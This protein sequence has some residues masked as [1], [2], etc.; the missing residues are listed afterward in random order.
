METEAKEHVMDGSHDLADGHDRPSVIVD[1][2]GEDRVVFSLPPTRR[3]DFT[4]VTAFALNKSGSVLLNH[5]LRDLCA[6]LD[7]PFVAISEEFF[8]AGVK[9]Q[10]APP[11]TSDIFLEKGYCYGGFRRWPTSFAI[12]ILA[13]SRPVL[14]VRDPRDRL[15]SNYYSMRES[16]SQPGKNGVLKSAKTELSKRNLAKSLDIDDYV[17]EVAPLFLEQLELYRDELCARH[18]VKIYRYE[19]VIYDK[20]SWVADLA[21]HFGWDIPGDVLRQI[22]ARN[23]VIPDEEQT[24]KHVRQVHPGNFE[25]KLQPPTIDYLTGYFQNVMADFGYDLSLRG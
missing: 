24:G 23:D 13:T 4:S 25:R 10:E 9:L 7:V 3:P 2:A 19:D 16:H 21:R 6:Y 17:R 1:D 20:P 11:S 18:D 14:L 22:A 8:K 15:V 5:I 12:P